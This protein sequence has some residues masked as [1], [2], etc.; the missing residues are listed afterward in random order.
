MRNET[1]SRR[2][3]NTFV[4]EFIAAGGHNGP[5]TVQTAIAYAADLYRIGATP[6]VA[7]RAAFDAYQ[8]LARQRDQKLGLTHEAM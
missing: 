2:W 5:V 6:K 7:G 1:P 4:T 3:T 8:K